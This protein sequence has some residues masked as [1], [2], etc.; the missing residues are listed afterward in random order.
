MG[1][2]DRRVFLRYRGDLQVISI[3]DQLQP[4]LGANTALPADGILGSGALTE[5][6]PRQMA[7]SAD[8]LYLTINGA[9][10]GGDTPPSSGL[11]VVNISGREQ[12]S[13]SGEWL[14]NI[15]G[16]VVT[17][18]ATGDL[19][20]LGE[21][22]SDVVRV[23]SIENPEKPVL[24]AMIEVEFGVR[25]LAVDARH[26]VVSDGLG[27]LRLIDIS[28]PANPVATEQME[29]KGLGAVAIK[30]AHVFA[31]ITGASESGPEWHE[32][33][34]FDISRESELHESH[35]VD[36]CRSNVKDMVLAA[37]MLYVVCRA[38]GLRVF[39][40]SIPS[41][42]RPRGSLE[43]D[44]RAEGVFVAGR[45]AYVATRWPTPRE[46]QSL[47]PMPRYGGLRVINVADPDRLRELGSH[48][49]RLGSRFHGTL[50]NWS[51]AVRGDY[52]MLAL[53]E[54]LVRIFDV[55]DP[56]DPAMVGI[57]DT[58]SHVSTLVGVGAYTFA[59]GRE[60]GLFVLRWLGDGTERDTTTVFLPMS[61]R[62]ASSVIGSP[63]G[64]RER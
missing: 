49:T 42:P 35:R 48:S 38:E 32:L 1:A 63:V 45:L 34:S 23:Y 50:M 6:H 39:D 44:A 56:S 53:D 62:P 19:L 57:L 26:V 60:G 33:V 18:G 37:N 30:D 24:L 15:P 20:F 28:D 3:D 47:S 58:P 16:D 25:D 11:L 31:S 40:V 7:I 4:L 52:A 8:R 22:N 61:V 29:L 27:S 17:A 9:G 59:S 54:K 21:A 5:A 36:V 46:E 2:V 41:N 10:V 51:V 12:P 43:V 14:Q 64:P 55:S 13:R